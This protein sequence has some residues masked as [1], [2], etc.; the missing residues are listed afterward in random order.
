MKAPRFSKQLLALAIGST[1]SFQV[2]A[3]G[4]A[5]KNAPLSFSMQ[6]QINNAIPQFTLPALNNKELRARDQQKIASRAG[7]T[8]PSIKYA[9]PREV[10]LL[11]EL[12][13]WQNVI[14]QKA[15]S[16]SDMVIWRTQVSSPGALSLN[17][18]FAQYN[19][20]EG[21][22]LHIYT[23]DHSQKIRPFTADDNET[24]GQLWTPIIAGDT[25]I[26][27]VN[28]PADKVDELALELSS[29]NHGYIGDSVQSIM[30]EVSLKS[31]SCNVDV[32]CPEGDGWRDQIRSAAAYSTGGGMFCSGSALNNT[33][34]DGRGFFLTADHCGIKAHN[35]PSMVVYWN[36]QNS[37]CRA[38]GSGASGGNG[39]GQLNQFSTGAIFRSGNSDTD[40]TLV[41]LD[42]PIDPRFNVYLA[43]WDATNNL[44]SSAV[45][46]HHPA[47][48][49][50]RISFEHDPLSF[51]GTTHLKVNDWDI[52]TTE[53]GSS[54]S[55][56]FN[57]DKRVVGQLTGGSAACGN[58][59]FD[60]Y[61]WL[62]TSWG[63]SNIG[64]YLDAAGTGQ[65]AIDGMNANGGPVPTPTPTP[66]P[67]GDGV[68]VYQHC[69]FGGYAVSLEAGN[70]PL[71][72]LNALGIRNNDVSSV[73]VPEGY[74]IEMFNNDNYSGTVV[75]KTADDDC[76]VNDSFNDQLTSIIVTKEPVE[77]ATLYQHC[78]FGGYG[79][80]LEP[81][82]YT[83]A[84]LRSLGLSNDDVSSVSVA[85]GY[86]IELYQHD[87]FGGTVITK[88]S[89][90]DCLVNDN[91]NDEVSSV[92]ISKQ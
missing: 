16:Q 15:K 87:N 39:D 51:D 64:Q 6:K 8:Q 35:A 75:T 45:G 38:P 2:L 32:V 80:A 60:V 67:T 65:R 50:K 59:G 28:L 48:H 26:L 49:E 52:G 54:G 88:T 71:S 81:G 19:M 20:P 72:Q 1:L 79:I 83:L 13:D 30:A 43:G 22:S 33:A 9:E 89:N 76:L 61:G 82:R 85:A 86:K 36:Y 40:M 37:T 58:D 44:P 68:T 57:Q 11:P 90:D 62:N 63:N 18:G 5:E 34:F 74:T 42:D 29:V 31:G 10:S 46:I 78:N 73:R 21:G 41:E 4:I 23:P 17:L 24:H 77:V 55:P 3:E 7:I 53:P 14:Q 92:V 27:E 56:L 12:T 47:V 70:Y 84:D 25:V 91:F 69:N 66:P